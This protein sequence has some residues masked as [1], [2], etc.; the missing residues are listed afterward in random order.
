ME[1]TYEERILAQKDQYKDTVDIHALPEIFHIWSHDYVG[2]GLR[3]VFEVNSVT[4]FYVEAFLAASSAG[5]GRRNFLSLGCGDGTVEIE[6]ARALHERGLH[7][8]QFVCLDLSED[9]LN[10]FTQS[11]PVDLQQNFSLAAGDLNNHVMKMRF[12]AIMANHSL[13]HMVEL[14]A[15]FQSVYENLQDEGIFVTS[16]MIGRNGH[17]RWPEAKL[18]VDYFWPFLSPLQRENIPLRRLE[19]SFLDHDC[20]TEGFEGIR[21]Q[22][23]LPL[24]LKQGFHAQKFFGFGGII[25][26]FIDRSFGHNF[27]VNDPSDVFLISRIGVLNEILLDCGLI[28]PTMMFAYFVKHQ[29]AERCYRTRSSRMA[30]REFDT[31][32]AWLQDALA[33][34]AKRPTPP[35][36]A[37]TRADFTDVADFVK[38]NEALNEA[39]M[40]AK[41]T[42][43]KQNA[44][45]EALQN[46]TSWR[47]TAP[48]RAFRSWFGK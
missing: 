35:E 32:P 22:E 15:I 45:I 2:P 16:D 29:T 10:R 43:I 27:S 18:F 6:I 23:V 3:Q 37:F 14:E 1:K 5:K 30:I 33:D 19:M 31:N 44:R 40:K 36:F 46:S 13:H 12:D 21:A 8:F 39:L 48:I 47:L 28:K 41:T 42:I 26:V 38:P 25:D 34:M 17:M 7:E 4:Q 24:I 11:I 20:S 9:L